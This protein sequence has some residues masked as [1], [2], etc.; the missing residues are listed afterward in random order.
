MIMK[1]GIASI[2]AT[3]FCISCS[4]TNT[5]NIAKTAFA[6]TDIACIIFH[7]VDPL[8]VVEQACNLSKNLEPEILKIESTIAADRANT[9]RASCIQP[10][11]NKKDAG[12]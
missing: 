6:A 9:I 11:Q 4:A 1:L 7:S 3:F 2:A 12:N 5:N 10:N 8:P